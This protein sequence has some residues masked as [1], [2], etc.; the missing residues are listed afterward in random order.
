MVDSGFFSLPDLLSPGPIQI[1]YELLDTSLSL[2][3]TMSSFF[4]DDTE[5]AIKLPSDIEISD[6]VKCHTL[7][8][9]NRT[10]A[11]SVAAGSN[12]ITITDL[13]RV[14][15][16]YYKFQLELQGLTMPNYLGETAD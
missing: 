13:K 14:K 3:L 9:S 16:S 11:F 1:V 7:P 8:N 15:S 4:G 10:C 2:N 6:D 5:L 12:Q